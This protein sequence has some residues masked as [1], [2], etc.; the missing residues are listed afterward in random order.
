MT[1]GKQ[2]PRLATG[3]GLDIGAVAGI[4]F[5]LFEQ[6]LDAHPIQ[7]DVA[8]FAV[9]QI[10]PCRHAQTTR[11]IAERLRGVR[12]DALNP[13]PHATAKNLPVDPFRWLGFHSG[14]EDDSR[15][16]AHA[17]VV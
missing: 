4:G 14:N 15:G 12:V 6:A 9:E 1:E 10:R 3:E 16:V 17:G 11:A 5:G 2:D 8:V 13:R 7:I